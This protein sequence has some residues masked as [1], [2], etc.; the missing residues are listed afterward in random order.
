MFI[1][2][3]KSRY[4]YLLEH[5]D[6][7]S[8]PEYDLYGFEKPI[9]KKKVIKI[10]ESSINYKYRINNPE[11]YNARKIVFVNVRSGKLKKE[12]CKICGN[13]KSEA[14]HKD[15]SKP[16]DIIWLCKEHHTEEHSNMANNKN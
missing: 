11:K 2:K 1:G 16:L 10:N 6:R 9:I 13:K 3:E 8:D 15:Y 12:N 14:H 5:M 7:I 4:L